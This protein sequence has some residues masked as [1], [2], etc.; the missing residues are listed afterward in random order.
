MFVGAGVPWTPKSAG[1]KPQVSKKGNVGGVPLIHAHSFAVGS[2][3]QTS[4]QKADPVLL[5][6]VAWIP[7]KSQRLPV[8]SV[9]LMAFSRLAGIF[10]IEGT[11]SVP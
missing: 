11:P 7:P 9:Q 6:V 1:V 10:P 4:L 3:A 5:V 2:N 8:E